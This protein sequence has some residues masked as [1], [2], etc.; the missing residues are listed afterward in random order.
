MQGAIPEVRP[1]EPCV[2]CVPYAMIDGSAR[3]QAG[4]AIRAC[5][6]KAEPGLEGLQEILVPDGGGPIDR[7]G[8]SAGVGGRGQG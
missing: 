7:V 1:S 5:V 4:E 3:R 8:V 2:G 6:A